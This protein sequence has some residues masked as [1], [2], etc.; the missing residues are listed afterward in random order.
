MMNDEAKR[1]NHDMF[2]LKSTRKLTEES[3]EIVE[4]GEESEVDELE[5]R[6]IEFFSY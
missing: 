5:S 4:R 2:Q 1:E 6:C 3:D